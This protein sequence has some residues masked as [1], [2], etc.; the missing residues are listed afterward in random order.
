MTS[1]WLTQIINSTERYIGV[2]IQS[3]L[4]T[5]AVQA[6]LV[7]LVITASVMKTLRNL[8]A[9]VID[10]SRPVGSD[11]SLTNGEINNTLI[12]AVCGIIYFSTL[13]LDSVLLLCNKIKHNFI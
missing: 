5:Q 4:S 7:R 12:T 1:N 2:R 13:Q 9:F 11:R 3:I 6:R 8:T 10:V